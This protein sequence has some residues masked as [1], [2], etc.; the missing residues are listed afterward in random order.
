GLPCAHNFHV[1]CIDQ[2]LCLNVKCPRCRCSVFPNLDLSALSNLQSSSTQQ[3]SSQGNTET[4]EARLHK[5]PTTKRELLPETSVSNSPG[6]YRHRSGAYNTLNHTQIKK[7][8]TD[9][10]Y[11]ESLPPIAVLEFSEPHRTNNHVESKWRRYRFRGHPKSKHRTNVRSNAFKNQQTQC[12][13]KVKTTLDMGCCSISRKDRSR[14]R[15]NRPEPF[16]R[17][18]SAPV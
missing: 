5:K 11:S 15:L 16:R 7:L 4:T 1:E 3:P 13:T 17:N 8:D 18:G 12:V 9:Q 6:P 14:R 10:R 2:W